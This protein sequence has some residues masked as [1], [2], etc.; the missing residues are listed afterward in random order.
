M[1]RLKSSDLLA[2]GS[3]RV[4]VGS[5]GPHP[6]KRKVALGAYGERV[7]ARHLQAQGM[8]IVDRNW[9]CA[10]GEIDLVAHDGSCLVVCEVKTRRTTTYGSPVEAITWRKAARLRRLAGWWVQAHPLE[11]RATSE[12]RVDVVGVVLPYAGAPVVEHLRGALA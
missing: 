7:A 10:D 4:D 9:R 3:G 11:A 5:V 8:V 2:S 6:D 1:T 12:I